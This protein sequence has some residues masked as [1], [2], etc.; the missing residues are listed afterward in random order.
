MPTNHSNETDWH[1]SSAAVSTEDIACIERLVVH[2]WA[3]WS[4]LDSCLDQL[5]QSVSELLETEGMTLRSCDIDTPSFEP[6]LREWRVLNVPA[7]VLVRRGKVV[8]V[9]YG[10]QAPDVLASLL[11]R[12]LA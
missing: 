9:C 4:S 1:P 12:W 5:L 6:H 3:S 10:I 2:C 8:Q 7:L 11:R